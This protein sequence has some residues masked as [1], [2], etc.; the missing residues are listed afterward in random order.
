MTE[1]RRSQGSAALMCRSSHLLGGAEEPDGSRHAECDIDRTFHLSQLTHYNSTIDTSPP[2]SE[3]N[4][5]CGWT[6]LALVGFVV[7]V[8]GGAHRGRH[9]AHAPLQARV[10]VNDNVSLALSNNSESSAGHDNA[11]PSHDESAADDNAKISNDDF[12]DTN[13]AFMFVLNVD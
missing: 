2:V 5:M 10:A 11:T 8:V 12:N 4:H 13:E 3:A 6:S 1:I 9:R 7:T